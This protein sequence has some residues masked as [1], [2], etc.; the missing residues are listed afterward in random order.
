MAHLLGVSAQTAEVQREF[1]EREHLPDELLSDAG[2]E[3]AKGLGRPTFEYGGI[4]L[5][6]RVK[7]AVEAGRVVRVW[8]SVFPADRNVEEVLEWLEGRRDGGRE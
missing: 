1:R 6:K 7:M 3:M 4:R 8:Y 5:L 2:L